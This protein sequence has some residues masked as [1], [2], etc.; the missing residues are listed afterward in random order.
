MIEMDNKRLDRDKITNLSRKIR[1]SDTIRTESEIGIVRLSRGCFID[2]DDN[3]QHRIRIDAYCG[4]QNMVKV[5]P[6]S[7]VTGLTNDQILDLYIPKFKERIDKEL[8]NSD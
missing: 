3:K 6:A 5:F 1:S 7:D 8:A 4:D 2:D